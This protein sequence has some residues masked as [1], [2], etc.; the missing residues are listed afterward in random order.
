[1]LKHHL[2]AVATTSTLVL[3][4]VAANSAM[5]Q[6]GPS[7]PPPDYPSEEYLLLGTADRGAG[8]PM[9]AV[10]PS[11][12]DNMIAVAM[13]SIQQ[14]HGVPATRGSTGDYHLNANSTLNW[15]AVTND[16]GITWDIGTQEDIMEDGRFGRCPDAIADVT[17]DGVFIAGCEPRETT[18]IPHFWGQSAFQMS[19]DHGQ[20]WGPNVPMVSDFELDRFALG[21][22][23]ISGAWPTGAENAAASN[24][25][26]DRPFTAIDDSTGVIYGVA[27]GGLTETGA[28]PGSRR[29][30]AYI[31]A[32]TDGGESF[33]TIYSW[34]SPEVQQASRG[35]SVTA[36]HGL[37]AV[38]FQAQ[39]APGASDCPCT[40]I[41]VSDDMGVSF[42]YKY[43]A[44]VDAAGTSLQKIS[45]DPTTPGR[46]AMLTYG[47]AE[48]FVAVSEDNGDTW[49]DFVSAG[50]TPEATRFNK[51]A[52]EYSRDGVVG[53]IW[54]AYYE[55]GFYDIWSSISTNGG[56][57][58]KA[59]VR[60]SHAKS[61]PYD[62]RRN[63]GLFGDDIQDLSM[64][65]ENIHLVWGDSRSGFQAVWYG[66][67]PFSAF[68]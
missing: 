60:V 6:R 57:E 1:M 64:D 14:L 35:I 21:L 27:Q 19:H 68:D 51:P 48:Y 52:F 47:D 67:V 56:T 34:D 12:P 45:F 20:T 37:V 11:N 10:D 63:A 32:S 38:S 5:A 23:P 49:S 41:G 29:S 36:G 65:G 53:L 28:A 8:E 42:T 31:T 3:A 25:P 26:W 39:S 33:G 58:W 2:S 22:A 17:A 15:L 46:I 44:N 4:L 30:Q 13:G 50:T 54:R 43:L 24:S 62:V 9:I 59:P 40:V 66:R 18:S 16:G 61:P 7:V 55:D